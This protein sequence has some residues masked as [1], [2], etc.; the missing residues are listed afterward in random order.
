MDR[1]SAFKLLSLALVVAALAACGRPSTPSARATMTQDEFNAATTKLSNNTTS[2]AKGAADNQA[3]AALQ[4]LP[5]GGPQG[6]MMSFTALGTTLLSPGMPSAIIGALDHGGPH[7][8]RGIYEF[9]D[10]DGDGVA[11]AWVQTGDSDELV[12]RWAFPNPD[13]ASH[14]AELTI[15][16]D[17]T[18]PTEL[19]N[20]GMEVIEAP[21][22]MSAS[23]TVDGSQ[24]ASVAFDADWY[25]APACSNPVLEPTSMALTGTLG[26][27]QHRLDFDLRQT[28]G[29][30]SAGIQGNVTATAGNDTAAI[31]WDL[32]AQGSLSRGPDCFITDA[33]VSSGSVDVG[34]SST[35]GGD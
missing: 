4:A 24:A 26:S 31:S 11:D 18:Q 35:V 8:L 13:A 9:Q 28:L 22:D 23:L 10:T 1:S 5:E 27:S 12:L 3:I 15:D 34:L 17:V 16:W 29:D 19:V 21:T 20:D 7:L 6:V 30:G 14:N 32:N 2:V 25:D 33:Q